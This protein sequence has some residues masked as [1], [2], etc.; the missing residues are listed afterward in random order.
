MFYT[1]SLF[2]TQSVMLS[3]RFIPQSVFYTE[4]VFYTQSVMLS[5]RFIPQSV[6]YTQSVVR[7]PQSVFY[8]DRLIKSFLC[9]KLGVPLTRTLTTHLYSINPWLI[10]F[11]CY[12]ASYFLYSLDKN[13]SWSQQST[14][15][16]VTLLRYFRLPSLQL[17]KCKMG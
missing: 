15:E 5:P 14:Y 4:S 12:N 17:S 2:Y 3:P 1:D 6:F 16:N 9:I 7:S 10:L 11:Q 13:L 8:T